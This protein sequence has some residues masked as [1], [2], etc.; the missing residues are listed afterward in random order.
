MIK[1]TRTIQKDWDTHV[2]HPLQS[3]AWG[4]FR[5]AMGID[6]VRMN[7]CLLTFHNI[8]FTPWTIGYF[9][10]GPMP[11][12]KMIEE[13]KRI[14]KEKH[15]IFIQLEPNV[16]VSGTPSRSQ[17]F[18]KTQDESPPGRWPQDSFQVRGSHHPLFTK[19]TFVLDLTKSEDELLKAMHP[20]T[21]Y[22]IRVAQKH[23]VIVKEDNSKE[24]FDVYLLLTQQTTQ[25][26]G[27]YAH[28]R[29]YHKKMWETLHKAGIAHLWTAT[30]ENEILAAWII[31]IWKDTVYYP[32]GAS[33]RSHREVMAPNLLLWEIARWAKKQGL[34]KFDL[35]GALGPNL[36]SNDP[37]YGFHR[38]KEG[39]NPNLVEFIGSYDLIINPILY[40]LYK[41]ADSVRWTVLKLTKRLLQVSVSP[42]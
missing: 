15:A 32:Y 2:E 3:W 10:K 31:F 40:E 21:R 29:N 25:R 6:V 20:K 24:A 34:K 11:T 19:F 39:Y 17:S 36:N 41:L 4:E 16:I 42:W 5:K 37:W 26:Q 18:E 7:G 23:N 9:P 35:W 8:P 38:F 13:L 33:S 1:P 12:Q 14:G 27:F 30:Q 28:T 22:N